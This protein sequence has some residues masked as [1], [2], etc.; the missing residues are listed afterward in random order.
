M[1]RDA[2]PEQLQFLQEVIL[3]FQFQDALSVLLEAFSAGAVQHHVQDN[4]VVAWIFVM[5]M[6]EPVPAAEMNFNV[7]RKAVAIHKNFRASE[8]RTGFQVPPSRR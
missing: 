2:L 3:H 1:D 5:A 6:L 4:V 8:I 7:A